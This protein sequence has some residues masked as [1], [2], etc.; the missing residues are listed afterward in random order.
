VCREIHINGINSAM[1]STYRSV[2]IHE[3]STHERRMKVVKSDPPEPSQSRP[4]MGSALTFDISQPD[5]LDQ[6]LLTTRP[7]ASRHITFTS[8]APP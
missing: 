3:V 2:E 6:L 1:H 8:T 5:D 4:S 7:C